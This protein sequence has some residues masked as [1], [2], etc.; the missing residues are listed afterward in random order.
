MHNK[1]R[2]HIALQASRDRSYSI[3]EEYR[4]SGAVLVAINKLL[5]TRGLVDTPL[6]IP[7]EPY[8]F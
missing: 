3:R 4:V 8:P 7:I 1:Q 6:D 5:S 2:S